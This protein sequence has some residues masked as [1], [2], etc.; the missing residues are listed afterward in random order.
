MRIMKVHPLNKIVTSFFLVFEHPDNKTVKLRPGLDLLAATLVRAAAHKLYIPYNAPRFGPSIEEAMKE[1]PRSLANKIATIDK[2]QKI[3]NKVSLFL[4][5][6]YEEAKET[7]LIFA[8]NGVQDFLYKLALASTLQA[9][10][11]VSQSMFLG[12]FID[13]LRDN[14]Q[15]GEAKFRL[16]QLY[17]VFHIYQAPEKIDTLTMSPKIPIPSIY[18][19]ISDLLEEAEII[20]LSRDRYLLG[21]PSKA[22]TALINIKKWKRTVLANRKYK[23]YVGVAADLIQIAG[24]SV[25]VSVPVTDLSENLMNLLTSTY[26]PPLI[27]LD[28]FRVRICKAVSPNHFP[29]F[30]MPDGA[31][32]GM[33]EEYFHK[34]YGVP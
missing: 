2:D 3:Y 28:Y 5:P 33:A 31:T 17:G 27:D 18:Q 24:D 12:H 19:R 10:A 20:E 14:V 25:G 32:R 15:D 8:Y 9:E 13:M 26:N 22:K 34:Y 16:D 6:I 21:I 7:P 23:N 4:K 1:Y 30:I 11:D 29:N